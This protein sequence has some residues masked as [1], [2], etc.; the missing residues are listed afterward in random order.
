MHVEGQ[1]PSALASCSEALD[2]L[3]MQTF[4]CR[5]PYLT[6]ERSQVVAGTRP[7]SKSANP[8]GDT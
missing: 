2:A 7:D 6:I 3:A 4:V 8:Q 5:L 1:L